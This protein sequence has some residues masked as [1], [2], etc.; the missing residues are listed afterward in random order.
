VRNFNAHTSIVGTLLFAA[1]LSTSVLSGCDN[2]EPADDAP[3]FQGTWTLVGI[4]DADGDKLASFTSNFDWLTAEFSASGSATFTA[5]RVDA[6]TTVVQ[7]TYVVDTADKSMSATVSV[8]SASTV[9]SF[10]YN[11]VS[12]NKMDLATSAIPLNIAFGTTLVG[13]AEITMDRSE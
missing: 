3:R 7:G 12:D 1:L 2:S 8:G 5:R 13:T 9:L 11:F 10:D 4:S 6:T